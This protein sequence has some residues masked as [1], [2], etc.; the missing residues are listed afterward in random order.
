[1]KGLSMGPT[2]TLIAAQALSINGTLVTNK[3]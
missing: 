3:V 1:M 2:D